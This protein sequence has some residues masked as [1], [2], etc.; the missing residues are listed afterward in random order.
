[1]IQ[2][3]TTLPAN[4]VGPAR[5][6]L[7]AAQSG[8]SNFALALSS[9]LVPGG[10]IKA[11]P[12]EAPVAD[13]AL[14]VRQ[15]VAEPG[16][17]L[18]EIVFD[19]EGEETPEQDA[20]AD[21]DAPASVDLP[22]WFAL[23]AAPAPDAAP[24]VPPL[25]APKPVVAETPQVAPVLAESALPN[26]PA[27]PAEPAKAAPAVVKG[28]LPPIEAT[29][30]AP[31]GE[32]APA[33][34]GAASLVGQL[35]PRRAERPLAL[36]PRPA[37]P[38]DAEVPAAPAAAPPVLAHVVVPVQAPVAA[39][40]SVATAPAAP[41][42]PEEPSIAVQPSVAPAS[43]AP[44]SDAPVAQAV[45]EPARVD[46]PAPRIRTVGPVAA[47]VRQPAIEPVPPLTVAPL[48]AQASPS[49]PVQ[50]I[51]FA[52]LRR[53]VAEADQP[54]V[55]SIAAPGAASLQQV[56][57]TPDAQQGTLD[58][59]RQ[60]WLGKM[61]E[62]I[63]AMREAAPVKE[64]RLSLVPDALGKVDI[65]VR[66]EGDRVH[67]HFAAET[68][69]ARQ[70]LTDAQPRLAELAEQRGV[71]L[72]QTSVDMGQAGANAQSGQR[73]NE[74][75]RPQNPTAPA[76]ARAAKDQLTQSDDRVA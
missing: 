14:A 2:I 25:I 65:S 26:A 71:R 74:A 8:T 52:P 56:T 49:A 51:A 17:E 22:F 45:S 11:T 27:A 76:S 54:L 73:H 59:R 15:A 16:K 67:V 19:A 4:S 35:P 30:L 6:V 39:P 75:Q 38:V 31:E 63:E 32:A 3:A 41:V 5:P 34:A 55:T 18:P 50:P 13:A 42:L 44:R 69:A 1:M 12:G 21:D 64:T 28:A 72:G 68:Q 61:V 10:A 57:A 20:Q 7:L 58:M 40:V 66:Q 9:L 36:V 53:A 60:E 23:P 43:A 33:V 70:I 24:V 48:I 62:T 47:P 46:A 29:P 37:L